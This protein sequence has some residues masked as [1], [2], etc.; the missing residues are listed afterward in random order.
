MKV[1]T[2]VRGPTVSIS[3]CVHHIIIE[4]PE[5]PVSIGVCKKCGLVKEYDTAYGYRYNNK[6]KEQS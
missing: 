4:P 6:P 3:E 2:Q 5:G 1:R